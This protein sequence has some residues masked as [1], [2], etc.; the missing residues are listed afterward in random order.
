LP[1]ALQTKDHRVDLA[2]RE[3]LDDLPRLFARIAGDVDNGLV[4]IGRR[5]LRSNN[6]WMHNSARLIKG[7]DRCTLLMHPDDAKERGLAHESM[8]AVASRVGEVQVKLE[9]TDAIMRGVVSLPHGFGHGRAG[10]RLQNA[11]AHAG[12]SINDLTDSSRVDALSGN[13]S[14]NG[15]PVAVRA[16]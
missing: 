3:Y 11:V 16:L 1:S 4:L 12:V 7:A 14:L 13:A 15:T 10:V 8:V 6:S 9:V 2:P 5:D